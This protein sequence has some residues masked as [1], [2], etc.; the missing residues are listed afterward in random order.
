MYDECTL[1]IV[2]HNSMSPIVCKQILTAFKVIM[3]EDGTDIGRR[4]IESLKV[5]LE[6]IKALLTSAYIRTTQTTSAAR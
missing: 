6:T 4:K 1:G 5:Y 3:G 2:H